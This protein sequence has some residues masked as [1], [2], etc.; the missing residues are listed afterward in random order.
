MKPDV[1][2][3]TASLL[4]L[5]LYEEILSTSWNR[6]SPSL[7]NLAPDLVNFTYT[8]CIRVNIPRLSLFSCLTHCSALASTAPGSIISHLPR[9][10][11]WLLSRVRVQIISPQPAFASSY[12]TAGS[13][14]LQGPLQHPPNNQLHVSILVPNPV[15]SLSTRLYLPS[16]NSLFHCSVF[17]CMFYS[18]KTPSFNSCGICGIN[19]PPR[20]FR[21]MMKKKAWIWLKWIIDFMIFVKRYHKNFN[22]CLM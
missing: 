18:Q 10:V 15:S 4:K 5:N 14:L 7:G 9:T 22:P 19:P 8:H 12:A 1:N 13:T 3:G 11:W 21:F 16:L 17:S 20:F 6:V 2:N